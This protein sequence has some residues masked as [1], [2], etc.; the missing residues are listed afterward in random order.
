M[1]LRFFVPAAA[2]AG[3]YAIAAGW[4]AS[5]EAVGNGCMGWCF[6]VATFPEF[7]ALM[8]FPTNFFYSSAW[9]SLIWVYGIVS[10]GLNA[11]VLYVLFGGIPWW[12]KA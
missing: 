9:Q 2:V 5:R 7:F 4:L 10:I 8:V 11:F 3:L 12:R 1:R 6:G